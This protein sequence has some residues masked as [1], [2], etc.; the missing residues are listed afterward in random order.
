MNKL[1]DETSP[2]L[3]QHADNPVHW[4]PWGDEALELARREDKPILLSIGYS[5]CHWCHVMAHESFE[6]DDTAELMNRLYVNIKVDREERPDI[7]KIYQSAHQL[8]QR[9]PG[10][11]PL[12]VFLNPADQRPFFAGTYFPKHPQH[13]L[14]SFDDLLQKAADYFRDSRRELEQH[15]EAIVDALVQIDTAKPAEQELL[16]PAPIDA[17][18]DAIA[19]SFDAQ[20]GGFGGA[21]KFPHPSNI[22][23]LLRH[24]RATASGDTPDKDALYMCALTLTRMAEGGIYDQLGGG[25]CRYSVDGEWMIPHFEKMLYDNGPLLA[26]YAQLW[27]VSG[28]DLYRRVAAETADWALRD[29][30]AADGGFFAALD[31]DSEGEEGKFYVWTPDELR[32]LLT[33]DE[34]RLIA[35]RFG[36]DRPANFEGSWHLRVTRSLEEVAKTAAIDKS[37]VLATLDKARAKLLQTRDAR[38]WPGRDDKILTSWNALMIRGLAIASR[39]LQR[40]EL[41]DAAAAGVDFIRDRLVVDDRLLATWKDGRARFAAYLDDYAFLLDATLEL[42]QAQWDT[43]HLG[44]ATWLANRLLADFA[45]AE[46]GGFFFTASDHETLIHRSKSMSDEAVPSGN[47]VAALALNRL[48]HLLGEPRYIDAAAATVRATGAALLDYPHAHASM[49]TALDE[50]LDPPEIVVI[51]GERARIDEW[52]TA[53]GAVYAPRRLLLAIPADESGLPDALDVRKP[54]ADTVAYVCRGTACTA[55][56]TSLDALAAE[57]KESN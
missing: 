39:S 35:M 17:A 24:W 38:I 8:I 2:Y 13:G 47:G 27:L 29:M 30:R 6:N 46:A 10:G 53:L 52:R 16:T 25:F 7:D 36:L 42:L 48:G 5:A 56:L 55:P 49:I 50:I 11:W 26:L 51:R 4:Q 34:Y 12:T 44:F 41:A 3:L 40:P 32:S 43:K 45:D 33:D 28:D 18:R 14:T 9:R 22:E 54:G 23:R 37:Q 15:G 21:P 19:S 1:G 57:L 31:A 20:Y